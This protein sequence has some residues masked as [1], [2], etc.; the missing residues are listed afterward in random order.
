MMKKQDM[1]SRKR[2]AK[3]KAMQDMREDAPRNPYVFDTEEYWAYANEVNDDFN[4]EF[5]QP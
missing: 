3:Q 2:L 1:E 4:R 5:I